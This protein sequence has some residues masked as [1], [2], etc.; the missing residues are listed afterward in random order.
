MLEVL[1]SNP[2]E[3]S[4][5]WYHSSN[6]SSEWGSKNIKFCWN[7]LLLF[8]GA[9][10]VVL[11]I[12]LLWNCFGAF[13]TKPFSAKVRQSRRLEIEPRFGSVKLGRSLKIE[14]ESKIVW[15]KDSKNTFEV[16][17]Q[18]RVDSLSDLVSSGKFEYPKRER[19]EN[20][21]FSSLSFSLGRS[22]YFSPILFW[23]QQASR[24]PKIFFQGKHRENQ[25][26][27]SCF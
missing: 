1:E 21:Q 8:C 15:F 3:L 20:L 4:S 25:M 22:K 13:S 6:V 16:S 12:E 23:N 27:K 10:F 9:Q 2:L 24:V 19:G 18:L 7:L 26:I 14:G 11:N 17:S 5:D